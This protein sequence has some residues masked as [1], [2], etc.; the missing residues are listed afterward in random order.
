MKHLAIP[1]KQH[2]RCYDDGEIKN[3]H[4]HSGNNSYHITAFSF[5]FLVLYQHNRKIKLLSVCIRYSIIGIWSHW[6]TVCLITKFWIWLSDNSNKAWD[7]LTTISYL[8]FL[9]NQCINNLSE[10]ENEN[11]LQTPFTMP[12]LKRRERQWVLIIHKRSDVFG[13]YWAIVTCGQIPVIGS[14]DTFPEQFDWQVSLQL[15]P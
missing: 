14:Q 7:G 9:Y 13:W 6:K 2:E 1:L 8:W 12:L 11:I 5:W 3:R 4:K 15:K 10:N